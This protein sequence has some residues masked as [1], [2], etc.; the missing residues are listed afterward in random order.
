MVLL[1]KGFYRLQESEPPVV[2]IIVSYVD[3]CMYE[4]FLKSISSHQPPQATTRASQIFLPILKSIMTTERTLRRS[5]NTDLPYHYQTNILSPCGWI[6]A[7][8]YKTTK[9]I[10]HLNSF[11][12]ITCMCLHM[13]IVMLNFDSESDFQF[14]FYFCDMRI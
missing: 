13:G 5:Q 11:V 12:K 6:P 3:T 4:Y 1:E 7:Q 9:P 2:C 10:N 8:R 14:L